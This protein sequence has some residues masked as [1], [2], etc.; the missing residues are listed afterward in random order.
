MLMVTVPL[1]VQAGVVAAFSTQ[2]CYSA[3][4]YIQRKERVH[5]FR[6]P[7]WLAFQ[8]HCFGWASA[9]VH[10]AAAATGAASCCVGAPSSPR[11][12]PK[13]LSLA[14]AHWLSSKGDTC[15]CAVQRQPR[16]RRRAVRELLAHQGGVLHGARRQPGHARTPIQLCRISRCAPTVSAHVVQAWRRLTCRWWYLE[17]FMKP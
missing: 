8:G 12:H 14:W 6:R 3:G 13:T 9:T 10:R 5:S 7:H 2:L 15:P 1:V 16:G 17:V 11:T 4:S